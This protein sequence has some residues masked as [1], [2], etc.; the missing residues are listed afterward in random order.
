MELCPGLCLCPASKLLW[1]YCLSWLWS[2]GLSWYAPA[3]Q[4]EAITSGLCWPARN[5][6]LL[7]LPGCQ[8]VKIKIRDLDSRPL[9]DCPTLLSWEG[10][11][12]GW[13]S[14]LRL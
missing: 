13:L 1:D 6:V 12:P 8:A 4:T 11:M 5:P 2:K 3:D 7:L 10:E 14:W 9:C